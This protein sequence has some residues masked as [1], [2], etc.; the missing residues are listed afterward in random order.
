M[1]MERKTVEEG[2]G[3]LDKELEKVF[4]D[5][6]H[7]NYQ[8]QLKAVAKR[9]GYDYGEGFL[10]ICFE[11]AKKIGNQEVVDDLFE[12]MLATGLV[13]A[14]PNV[15][16]YFG[17][18]S[19][20]IN[21]LYYIDAFT[22]VGDKKIFSLPKVY[23]HSQIDSPL[24]I[25]GET[26]TSKGLLAK[27]LHKIGK[28]RKGP[29]FGI[30]CATIPQNL[31]E[32]ELFGHKKGSFTHAVANKKGLLEIANGGSV[33]LDEIGKMPDFLQAKLLKSIE[34][35]EIWPIGR[36]EPVKIDV[37]F[38]AAA[39]PVDARRIIPDL[40]YRL[41]FP[42]CIQV[43]TLKERM[44]AE[45]TTVIENSWKRA[46]KNLFPCANI[47]HILE[48][49]QSSWEL[50]LK[51]EYPGNYREL[52]NILSSAIKSSQLQGR[53]QILLE[54]LEEAMRINKEFHMD[55]K[56]G[57]LPFGKVG[58]EDIKTKDIIDYANGIRTS[59]IETKIKMVLRDGKKLKA[60]LRDE[61]MP[62]GYDNF[63][64]KIRS[65]TGKNI[66]ELGT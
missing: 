23:Y 53:N 16:M 52:E 33:L 6:N 54:D 21:D 47:K 46:M 17:L 26:G 49:S 12:E 50:L 39:Q 36:T 59:I 66:R 31:F 3:N 22:P 61:G 9:N 18:S 28:R 20:G 45:P 37:R 58:L 40:L 30:N 4:A 38:I 7:V 34:E 43:P 29:F 19:E 42:D 60:V 57:V 14:D 48:L 13:S 44:K 10:D 11:S 65:I 64:K 55:K 24:L 25:I 2:S 56:E 35:K 51:S 62:R 8:S 15:V 27:V 63:M 1:E 32:S 5:W 41:G